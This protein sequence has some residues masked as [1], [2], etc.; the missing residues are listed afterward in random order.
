MISAGSAP[1]P[2]PPSKAPRVEPTGEAWGGNSTA[3]GMRRPVASFAP[4]ADAIPQAVA[5]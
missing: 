2:S 3:D 5:G 1:T 4:A